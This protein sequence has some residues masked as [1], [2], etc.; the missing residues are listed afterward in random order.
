[1]RG[2]RPLVFAMQ[3]GRRAQADA[4]AGFNA[5]ATDLG[6]NGGTDFRADGCAN[7]WNDC[8]SSKR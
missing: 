1:M 5:A 6:A 7:A 4:L 3:A 8:R 2:E